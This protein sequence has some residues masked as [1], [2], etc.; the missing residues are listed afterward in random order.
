VPDRVRDTRGRGAT[1]ADDN[2]VHHGDHVDDHHHDE[3]VDHDHH[4]RAAVSPGA[5]GGRR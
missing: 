1:E 4:D 3:L 2:D 5:S